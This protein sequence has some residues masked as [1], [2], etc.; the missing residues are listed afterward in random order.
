MSLRVGTT[1]GYQEKPLPGHSHPHYEAILY[2]GGTGRLHAG[3]R[4][5]VVEEG[6]IA[7]IPPDVL[8]YTMSKNHLKSICISGAFNHLI[9]LADPIIIRDGTRREGFLLAQMLLE[10]QYSN[11]E[12]CEALGNAFAHYILNH[13]TF[14]DSVGVAV[15]RIV[16]EIT[17]RYHDSELNISELLNNSGYAEDYIRSCFKKIV[18]KSPNAF[19]IEFRIQQACHLIDVYKNVMP[20]SDVAEQCGYLDYVNFCR[21][22]KQATGVSPQQYKKKVLLG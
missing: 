21:R 16:Q 17:R 7:I 6:S 2:F 3:G 12:Y 14:K 8:H 5:H 20:L 22:F 13:L 11:P 4:I 1:R 19:L 10:N 15:S 18:G 9:Q